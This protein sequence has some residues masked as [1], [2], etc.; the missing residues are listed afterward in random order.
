MVV[1][2]TTCT[3]TH[4]HIKECEHTKFHHFCIYS[5]PYKRGQAL[6]QTGVTASWTVLILFCSPSAWI[7]HSDP[8]LWPLPTCTCLPGSHEDLCWGPVHYS[9]SEISQAPHSSPPPIISINSC[10]ICSPVK[11]ATGATENLLQSYW[12]PHFHRGPGK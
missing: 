4:T 2:R 6:E 11:A 3:H 7:L 12:Y 9:D 1:L 5:N 8:Q 10:G